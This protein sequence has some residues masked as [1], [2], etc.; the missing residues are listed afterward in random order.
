METKL[1]KFNVSRGYNGVI[2][3]AG[4]TVEIGKFWAMIFIADGTA[5][6]VP[7]ATEETPKPK[8]PTKK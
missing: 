6:E 5:S 3:R 8:K 7:R 2:I 4:A 1:L